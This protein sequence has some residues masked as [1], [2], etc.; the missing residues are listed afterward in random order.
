MTE[1]EMSQISLD[2]SGT[3]LAALQSAFSGA[4]ENP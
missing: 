1:G 2:H 4:P 3:G